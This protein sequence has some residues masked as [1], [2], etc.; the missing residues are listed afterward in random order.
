MNNKH[1]TKSLSDYPSEAILQALEDLEWVEKTPGYKVDMDNWMVKTEDQCRVCQAGA[2]AMRRHP[3]TLSPLRR[4][5]GCAF[6][7]FGIIIKHPDEILLKRQIQAFDDLREGRLHDF[8]HFWI[9]DM[10]YFRLANWCEGIQN[11]LGE[12]V[13]YEVSPDRS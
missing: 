11:S 3:D 7:R 13:T 1:N 9:G 2:V 8:L 6:T 5:S 12:W 10:D 4:P